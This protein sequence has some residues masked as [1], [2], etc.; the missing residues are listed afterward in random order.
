M[1]DALH[2][3]EV[4]APPPGVSLT[5]LSPTIGTEV[6]GIDLRE[7]L[8][9]RAVAFLRKL[10][11]DRKVIFFRDQPLTPEQACTLGEIFRRN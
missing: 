11:L 8:D 3:R 10:W 5:H 4:I 6:S 7:P 1:D 9:A 2:A